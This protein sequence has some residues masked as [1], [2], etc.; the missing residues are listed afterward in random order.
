MATRVFRCPV[1]GLNAQGWF[2]DDDANGIDEQ[3][4]EVVTCLACARTHLVNRITGKA[5]G[6]GDA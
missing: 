3:T 2:S 1:T 5:L 4:Y 6:Y